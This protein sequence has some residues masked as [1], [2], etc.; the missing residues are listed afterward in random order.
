[1]YLELAI[2]KSVFAAIHHRE[3]VYAGALLLLVNRY[4]VV[5]I[6]AAKVIDRNEGCKIV[7]T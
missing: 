6:L 1:M 4:S 7:I 2:G 5:E 3:V